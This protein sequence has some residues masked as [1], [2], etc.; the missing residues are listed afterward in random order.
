[1]EKTDK[2]LRYALLEATRYDVGKA[3]RCYGKCSRYALRAVAAF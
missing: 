2:E 3:E 1:M